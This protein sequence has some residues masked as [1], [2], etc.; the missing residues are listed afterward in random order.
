MNCFAIVYDHYYRVDKCMEDDD[1]SG[2]KEDEEVFEK[3][4]MRSID[5]I[6]LGEPTSPTRILIEITHEGGETR[7]A[8]ASIEVVNLAEHDASDAYDEAARELDYS[9]L[10]RELQLR[11]DALIDFTRFDEHSSK[12]DGEPDAD[13]LKRYHGQGGE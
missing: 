8:T 1:P 9:D 11:V 13:I 2:F 7:D 4:S 5:K 12:G 6:R 10:E 3:S